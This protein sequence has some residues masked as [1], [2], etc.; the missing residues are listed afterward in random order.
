MVALA[1][2]RLLSLTV[3]VTG[4]FLLFVLLGSRMFSV[5]DLAVAFALLG[6]VMVFV[7][8]QGDEALR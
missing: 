4:I 3:V 2:I 8:T 1:L 6:V 7:T 5:L